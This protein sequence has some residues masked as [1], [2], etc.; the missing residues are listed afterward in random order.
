MGVMP[1]FHVYGMVTVMHFSVLEGLGMILMPRFVTEPVLKG[2]NKYPAGGLSPECR[3][4][5]WP[6][7]TSPRSRSTI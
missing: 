4:C 1:L 5:M 7:T 6:S 2:I 3:R